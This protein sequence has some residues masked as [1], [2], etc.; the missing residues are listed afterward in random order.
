LHRDA[1]KRATAVIKCGVISFY[2]KIFGMTAQNTQPTQRQDIGAE[3]KA[4]IFNQPESW[5]GASNAVKANAGHL[6]TFFAE[7]R[8]K[9]V[10]FVGCG[11]PY[12][13]DL[14]AAAVYRSLTGQWAIALPASE[15]LYHLEAAFPGKTTPLVVA[16]SR[17]GET[18]EL[19]AACRRLKDERNSPLVAISVS[20]GTTLER[21][22]DVNVY[23]QNAA[24]KSVAQTRS[25]SA[26]LLATLGTVSVAAQNQA[27]LNELEH[28]PAQ[29]AGYLERIKQPIADV[30]GRGFDRVFILGSGLRYGLAN[31]GSL[32]M[33]EMSI[34]N[35]E[36]FHFMEF[37]HGPQSM[38]DDH[39][40]IVGL[41]SPHA[42][43]AE[44]QVLH[45]LVGYGGTVVAVGPV[46]QP[47]TD[48]RYVQIEMP[49]GL[50][51]VAQLPF[52]MPALHLLAFNQAMRKDMNCDSPRNLYAWI[53][54]PELDAK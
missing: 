19:M 53:K 30:I 11:S 7:H 41:V 39:T 26:M 17:S 16:V 51:E 33:K 44:T 10:I 1:I 45:E 21:I 50:S 13:L 15:I 42:T 20:E 3:T 47:S 6:G 4:E 32:K 37:R 5:Q 40:L 34:T 24:E 48:P 25:F 14:T 54:L 9:P 12:Y 38:V 46:S 43:A 27:L 8:D 2:A 29:A 35:A 23:I 52:Y 22:A 31:E 28:I 36:P 18:S 49:G